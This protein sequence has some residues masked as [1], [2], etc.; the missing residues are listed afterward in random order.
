M[1]ATGS[2][3]VLRA[4]GSYPE[5]R[6]L[7]DSGGEGG[8]RT[9]SRSMPL[10]SCRLHVAVVAKNATLA[11]AHRPISPDDHIPTLRHVK[12]VSS[13]PNPSPLSWCTPSLLLHFV[14]F[15]SPFSMGTVLRL[16]KKSG[17]RCH[18]I[19]VSVPFSMGTVLRPYLP[20]RLKRP[21]FV[22]V[23]FSMGTV[24]RRTADLLLVRRLLRKSLITEL[25]FSCKSSN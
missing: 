3:E 9:A 6:C 20:L 19:V 24:L 12:S 23:P 16:R 22:S 21:F 14:R 1:F 11:V 10:L 5:K 8:I 18:M 13:W 4:P 15:Q 2:F 25:I 17:W 7:S